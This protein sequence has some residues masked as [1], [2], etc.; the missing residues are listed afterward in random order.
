MKYWYIIYSLSASDMDILEAIDQ[1]DTRYSY[2]HTAEECRQAIDTNNAMH[3]RFTGISNY[4]VPT[5]IPIHT[6]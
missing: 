5:I 6:Y 2:Y 3:L 1:K 4:I